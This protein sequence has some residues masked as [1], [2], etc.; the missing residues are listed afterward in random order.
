MKRTNSDSTQRWMDGWT[1]SGID[2]LPSDPAVYAIFVRNELTYIGAASNLMRRFW[3]HQIAIGRICG[4]DVAGWTADALPTVRVSYLVCKSTA[5]R[6]RKE[7]DLI[8][9]L[10]PPHNIAYKKSKGS[11]ATC[12]CC[13]TEVRV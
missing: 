9:T 6:R 5:D 3:L 2:A 7:S 10:Q 11:Y 1:T 13:G 8:F 4:R 12:P